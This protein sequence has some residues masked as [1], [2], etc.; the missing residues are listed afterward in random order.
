MGGITCLVAVVTAFGGVVL[1]GGL[2]SLV[3]ALLGG[4]VGTVTL[5]GGGEGSSVAF[6]PLAGSTEEFDTLVVRRRS[7]TSE[8]S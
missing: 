5:V 8:T 2:D 6:V 7:I 1:A 4:K 3:S